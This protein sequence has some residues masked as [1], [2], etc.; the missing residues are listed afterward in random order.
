MYLRW[1]LGINQTIQCKVFEVSK[2]NILPKANNTSVLFVLFF[3][4]EVKALKVILPFMHSID[5]LM[6]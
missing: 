1:A 5:V 3:V 4:H 6:I 2:K